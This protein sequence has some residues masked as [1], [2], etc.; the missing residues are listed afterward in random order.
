MMAHKSSP[1]NYPKQQFIPVNVLLS[2][3]TKISTSYLLCAAETRKMAS[4]YEECVFSI[5]YVT[6]LTDE[7]Q[8]PRLVTLGPLAN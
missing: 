7:V 1:C 3:Q 8:S 2:I 6:N 4:M 5:I